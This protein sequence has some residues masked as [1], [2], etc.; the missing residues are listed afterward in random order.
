[1]IVDS[2]DIE[3]RFQEGRA[4]EQAG[5]LE[6]A[7][8]LYEEVL[9]GEPLHAKSLHRLGL[10]SLAQGRVD[11]AVERFEAALRGDP[12]FAEAAD[13]LGRALCVTRRYGDAA[14]AFRRAIELRP[15]MAISYANLGQ[16]LESSGEQD[17]AEVE[18]G[19]A[20][21]LDATSL[22]AHRGL[23]LIHARRGQ[24]REAVEHLRDALKSSPGEPVTLRA[25]GEILL[26]EGLIHQARDCYERALESSPDDP[27]MLCEAAGVHRAAGDTDR[28]MEYYRRALAQRA[29]HQDALAGLATLL[30]E[31]GDAKSAV[32][33]LAPSI[34]SGRAGPKLLA[35]YATLLGSLGRRREGIVLLEG[36]LQ[37]T[38]EEKA[39]STLHFA[40][41]DLLD[42]DGSYDLAFYH[43]RRG[44]NIVGAPYDRAEFDQQIAR[45]VA[46]QDAGALAELPQLAANDETPIFVV[47]LPRSGLGVLSAVLALNPAIRSLGASPR[48]E[49]GVQA[50][51]RHAGADWPVVPRGLSAEVCERVA[52][53]TIA[54]RGEG[55]RRAAYFLD[56]TW[57]NF[58]YL[59]VIERLFPHARIVECVR[60]A[61]DVAVSC[62][63]R[64]FSSSRGMPFSHDLADVATVVNG[65]RKLMAH[66]RA[67]L[68]RQI[69]RVEYESLIQQPTETCT[70]LAEYIGTPF[71]AEHFAAA[72]S[73][74]GDD[75]RAWRLRAKSLRRYRHYREHLEAFVE[76]LDSPPGEHP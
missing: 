76:S 26:Q 6:K 21:E 10:L 14:D 67:T 46:T 64:D 11:Q 69:H 4:A 18:Y 70:G 38:L 31:N 5:D 55:E 62:Y 19:R 68:D 41:A 74:R 51:W 28:A 54:D 50:L 8:R 59:G 53:R 1:M 22:V 2:A 60:D 3:V 24:T 66:W 32:A 9:S 23:G 47:G 20:L 13:G 16:V 27:D 72:L 45:I 7:A 49:I 73:D 17:Q 33:R 48:V 25:L 52:R 61:R 65:Y 29:S 56:A 44:N 35:T 15:D 42:R 39:A 36:A 12:G 58:L 37:K 63:F 57:R 30:A 40:L 71:E 75:E 34:N 43:C